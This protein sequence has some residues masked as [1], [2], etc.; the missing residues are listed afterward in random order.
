MSKEHVLIFAVFFSTV[1]SK[2]RLKLVKA[3]FN[4]YCM[5]NDW[6]ILLKY[7]KQIT[8]MKLFK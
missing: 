5:Y 1:V 7:Q 4:Y 3:H 2:Y 6:E 8:K